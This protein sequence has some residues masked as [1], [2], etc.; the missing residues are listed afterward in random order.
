[1]VETLDT[2]TGELVTVNVN[3]PDR[4]NALNG[5]FYA[6]ELRIGMAVQ[7]VKYLNELKAMEI[8]CSN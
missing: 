5:G 3:D 1:M 8:D 2:T 4:K 7:R 6:R